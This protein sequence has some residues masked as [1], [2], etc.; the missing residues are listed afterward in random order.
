MLVA[1]VVLAVVITA[2]IAVGV[3]GEALGR[4]LHI[5]GNPVT[6]RRGRLRGVVAATVFVDHVVAH[7]LALIKGLRAAL[8]HVLVRSRAIGLGLVA[9]HGATH[10]TGGG[11]GSTTTAAAYGIADQ[12]AG[13]RTNHGTRT[14]IARCHGHGLVAAYLLGHGYLLGDWRGRQHTSSL[15]GKRHSSATRGQCHKYQGFH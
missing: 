2:V 4:G 9:Q 13:Q 7:G 1:T 5:E 11:S 14:G 6:G 12:A 3:A 15:L 10:H 8:T